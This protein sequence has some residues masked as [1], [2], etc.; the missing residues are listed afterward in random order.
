MRP[1]PQPKR[2]KTPTSD[3]DDD[4]DDYFKRQENRRRLNDQRR[5][6]QLE[7]QRRQE[8]QP[9]VPGQSKPDF[10][11]DPE[12]SID[13][14]VRDVYEF[15]AS[16]REVTRRA[17]STAAQRPVSTRTSTCPSAHNAQDAGPQIDVSNRRWPTEQEFCDGLRHTRGFEIVEMLGDGACMFRAVAYHVYGDQEMH[18]TVREACINYM[19]AN[20]DHFSQF[21]LTDFD[22]YLRYKALP[23][24]HGNHVEIQ[25]LSEMY[26][27]QIEVYAYDDV[28]IN[29]FQS[30][31]HAD[32][33]IRL[34]Y[35]NNNHYNAVFDPANPTFGVG[36]G[37]S[38]LNPGAADQAWLAQARQVS[39]TEETERDLVSQVQ[40]LSQAE[41]SSVLPSSASNTLQP[42]PSST[43]AEMMHAAVQASLQQA[44]QTE[45]QLFQQALL[46]SREPTPSFRA[47]PAAA[48]AFEVVPQHSSSAATTA[49]PTATSCI[50]SPG[51][52][53]DGD[54]DEEAMMAAAIAASTKDAS[55]ADAVL[56]ALDQNH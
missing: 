48:V 43:E 39:A 13:A 15:D 27:R 33:P 45:Q 5:F 37:F 8:E 42:G 4:D 38:D 34:S 9:V 35:H 55:E 12:D 56:S 32:A 10:A 49:M 23:A 1:L 3:P 21:V 11:Y 18:G 24:C 52:D 25:A 31:L 29:T 7:E 51:A 22:L 41:P 16:S 17:S 6:R 53:D 36:L 28:P 44:A 14:R 40:A 46:D 30:H 2:A 50:K 20:R 19:R 47:R 26:N 54:D